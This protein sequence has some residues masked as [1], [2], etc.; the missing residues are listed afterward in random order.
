ML[1]DV[2]DKYY[3]KENYNCAETIIH[4]ANEYYGLGL[5]DRDMIM[6]A[7]YGAGMQTANTCGALLSTIS[8]LALKFVEARA[9]ESRDL[10]PVTFL[11]T[12][13]FKEAF[14]STLCKDIRPQCFQKEIRC[15][16]TVHM[17]C[18]ILEEVLAEYQPKGA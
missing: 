1:K 9:H 6:L 4:A 15:Q 18:D 17:A 5:H 13:K 10:Q 8:V 11:L 16:K 3:F 12:K 7:G 14:S 2:A